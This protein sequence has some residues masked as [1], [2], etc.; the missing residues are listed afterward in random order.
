MSDL[1]WAAR[2]AVSKGS[3]LRCMARIKGSCAEGVL[4][5]D[6]LVSVEN[7]QLYVAIER[8][9]VLH[10]FR[11][12]NLSEA[13]FAWIADARLLSPYYCIKKILRD[14]AAQIFK[15]RQRALSWNT[16]VT[17]HAQILLTEQFNA[18][19]SQDSVRRLKVL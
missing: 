13:V 17:P 12:N 16:F 18:L 7:W 10:C 9:N 15:Q 6:Y 19:I 8:G 14:S 3:Y 5:H 1:Y 4:I 2:Q 11:S